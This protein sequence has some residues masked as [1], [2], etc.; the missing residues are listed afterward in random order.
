MYISRI[1]QVDWYIL[2]LSIFMCI[3]ETTIQE[4]QLFKGGNYSRKYG[5][6]SIESFWY[7]SVIAI[8]SRKWGKS[9][10]PYQNLKLEEQITCNSY[11]KKLI[12]FKRFS[13]VLLSSYRDQPLVWGMVLNWVSIN[14]T[15]SLVHFVGD[16]LQYA[17]V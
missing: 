4:R 3:T 8:W 9:L 2:L 17:K 6:W 11:S 15:T 14:T 10:T 5:I 16:T 1:Y 7:L 12:C 13:C